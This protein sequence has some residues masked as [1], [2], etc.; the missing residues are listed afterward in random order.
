[1]RNSKYQYHIGDRVRIK[2]KRQI[3]YNKEGTIIDIEPNMVNIRFDG[4]IYKRWY[5]PQDIEKI[6]TDIFND[7]DF[8]I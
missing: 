1:M 3:N 8:L 4:N 6:Y 7:K 5:I 2:N